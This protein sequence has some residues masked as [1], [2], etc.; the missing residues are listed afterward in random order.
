MATLTIYT[1]REKPFV[2]KG[3]K[4]EIDYV[5]WL[6]NCPVWRYIECVEYGPSYNAF[7]KLKEMQAIEIKGELFKIKVS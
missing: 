1:G 2:F 4:K 6:Y 7:L 5:L 3:S